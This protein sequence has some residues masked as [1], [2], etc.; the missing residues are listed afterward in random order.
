MKQQHVCRQ[1]E[2]LL[3]ED[4]E[5]EEVPEPNEVRRITLAKH[6]I[7][8]VFW[9]QRPVF[10][11]MQVADRLCIMCLPHWNMV[12]AGWVLMMLMLQYAFFEPE[13]PEVALAQLVLCGEGLGVAECVEVLL[14]IKRLGGDLERKVAALR[15]WGK[16]HTTGMPYYIFECRLSE[17]P[18]KVRRCSMAPLT[19][20][21]RGSCQCARASCHMFH[22][23]GAMSAAY[24]ALGSALS[25]DCL[26][27]TRCNGSITTACLRL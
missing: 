22:C 8:D 18:E 25:S 10:D 2:P 3:N 27:T 26:R 19:T 4:G 7:Q 11:D 13:R 5:P 14:A 1:A 12:V 9:S 6:C 17:R 21:L 20:S 15:F 24:V 16:V 23:E